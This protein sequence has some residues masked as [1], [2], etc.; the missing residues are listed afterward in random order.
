MEDTIIGATRMMSKPGVVAPVIIL[1]DH[2]WTAVAVEAVLSMD[3]VEEG[4][5]LDLD[6]TITGE[7]VLTTQKKNV[8]TVDLTPGG[9]SLVLV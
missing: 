8:G 3:V 2:R 7:T 6:G 4:V 5:G 1:I 9:H